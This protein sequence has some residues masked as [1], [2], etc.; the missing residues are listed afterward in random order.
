MNETDHP[1]YIY[2]MRELDYPPGYRLLAME[3]TLRLYDNGDGEWQREG[4]GEGGGRG[5][6]RKG[7]SR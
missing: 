7:G 3:S 1:P 2:R 6:E 4:K 5:G